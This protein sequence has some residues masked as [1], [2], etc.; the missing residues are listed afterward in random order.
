MDISTR[1]ATSLL[2][3]ILEQKTTK[4]TG[5]TVLLRVRSSLK[6]AS[7]VSNAK[8]NHNCM[9]ILWTLDH[10]EQKK[11]QWGSGGLLQQ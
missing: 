5:Y 7:A 1:A 6:T 8:V 11:K 3:A 10:E 9:T 2:G 4:V